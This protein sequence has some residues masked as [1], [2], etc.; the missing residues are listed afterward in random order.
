MSRLRQSDWSSSLRWIMALLLL[1]LLAAVWLS[2]AADSLTR[3]E[4]KHRLA[5]LHAWPRG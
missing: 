5:E 3:A 4:L 1:A 2:R